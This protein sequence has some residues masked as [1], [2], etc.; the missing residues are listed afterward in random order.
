MAPNKARSSGNSR[1]RVIGWSA[2]SRG[3]EMV[4]PVGGGGLHHIGTTESSSRGATFSDLDVSD[5][6]LSVEVGV[7]GSLSAMFRIWRPN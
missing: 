4:N 3:D 1:G 5:E 7:L 6:A 2:S